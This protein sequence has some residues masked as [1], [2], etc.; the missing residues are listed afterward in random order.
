VAAVLLTLL[1][2]KLIFDLH[3]LL[4]ALSLLLAVVGASVCA[5]S[6]GLS[7]ITPLGPVG[8]ATQALVGG[9]APGQPEVN[10]AAGSVVAGGATHTSILLWSLRAGRALGAPARSQVLA[11]LWGSVLGALL[12]A[13]AY[14]L[15]VKAYALGSQR[16]PAPTGIQWKAMGEVMAGGLAAL[17]PGAL[18]AV[19]A[20]AALG[21]VLAALGATRA[22]FFLPSAM[23]MGI[24]V[25][26]P[27]D[28][29]L[30]IL[31]GAVLVRAVPRLHATGPVAGA[32]LIAGDSLVG[33]VVALLTSL[34][35]L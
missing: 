20:A 28:Y 8:Q 30:A 9:L 14:V 18:P 27:V 25:L 22:G 33:V 21:L 15:L 32:G 4:T 2:G 19:S 1:F 13:P 31:L 12:C 5:R 35:L 6:A 11:A 23:A 7:D 34:G 24:G 3:P 26:V 29:S 10:I 17:P 16:L